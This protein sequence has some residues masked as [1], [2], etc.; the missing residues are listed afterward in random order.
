MQIVKNSASHL[1]LSYCRAVS[2]Y[3]LY[4]QR[5]S[6]YFTTAT[7]PFQKGLH[8]K[9]ISVMVIFVLHRFMSVAITRKQ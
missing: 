3:K 5:H 9:N 4:M 1:S 7:K 2:S 8:C 6:L